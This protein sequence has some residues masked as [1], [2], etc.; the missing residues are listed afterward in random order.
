MSV[1]E[2][3][4]NRCRNQSLIQVYISKLYKRYGKVNAYSIGGCQ[5]KTGVK[6]LTKDL[7]SRS[8]K[9]SITGAGLEMLIILILGCSNRSSVLKDFIQLIL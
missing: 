6:G 8:V 5:S 9:H 1:C 3:C 7:S 2:F 4:I